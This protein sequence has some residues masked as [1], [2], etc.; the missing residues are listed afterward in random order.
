MVFCV[1]SPALYDACSVPSG[2]FS[3]KYFGLTRSLEVG[4]RRLSQAV[5]ACLCSFCYHSVLSDVKVKQLLLLKN[6]LVLP[7]LFIPLAPLGKGQDFTQRFCVLT[8][9][10]IYCVHIYLFVHFLRALALF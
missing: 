10:C 4:R 5:H 1:A 3:S 2:N 9:V 8:Y 6:L 7:L